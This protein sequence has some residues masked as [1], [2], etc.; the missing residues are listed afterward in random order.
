MKVSSNLSEIR[1]LRWRNPKSTWGLVPTMGALHFGHESLIKRAKKE[2]E[3]VAVSIFV[4][5]IQ[6]N[7][8]GDLETYPV[9]LEEDLNILKK[10]KVDIVWTPDQNDI[11]TPDFQT[12]IQVERVATPLEGTT[13]PGHFKGVATIVSVLFN[14]FQPHRAYFGQKDAQQ[15]LV[16][17]QMVKDLK[18]NLEI[19]SCPTV[20]EEDGLAISSRNQILSSEGR[21]QAVCLFKALTAAEE[22]IDKGE[23]STEKVKKI[24]QDIISSFSLAKIDY[25]SIANPLTL[26]EADNIV[27]SVLISLAVYIENT[28]LIDNMTIEI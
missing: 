18:F 5:P 6:F 26:I 17:R 7:N 8:P 16:I 15:L 28:R 22:S 2:N 4:N 24:V 23:K 25:V 1:S 10:E 21:K 19:V 3:K 20:R 12:Y 11:Y 9:A 13:R 14:V 27:G